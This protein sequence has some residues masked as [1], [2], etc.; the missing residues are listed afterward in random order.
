MEDCIVYVAQLDD[1]SQITLSAAEFSR[2]FGWKNNPEM[3]TL[4]KLEGDK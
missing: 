3:A 4:F 2:K 1:G